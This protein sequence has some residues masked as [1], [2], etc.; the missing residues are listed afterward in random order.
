MQQPLN[1][2]TCGKCGEP[3]GRDALGRQKLMWSSGRWLCRAC[4][5]TQDNKPSMTNRSD[6]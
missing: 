2:K 4:F 1:Q 3:E 5:R 6:R